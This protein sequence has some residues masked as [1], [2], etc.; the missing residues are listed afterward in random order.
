MEDAKPARRKKKGPTKTRA[1]SFQT[2]DSYVLSAHFFVCLQTFDHDEQ[3][4]LLTT[5][6]RAACPCW[7]QIIEPFLLL[8][9]ARMLVAIVAS[10]L[11]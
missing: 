9:S 6:A 3:V 4:L 8:S 1:F 10:K 7:P 2:R 5:L 11:S